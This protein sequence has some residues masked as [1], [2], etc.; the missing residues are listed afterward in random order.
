MT[1][2]ALTTLLV[3]AL[4]ATVVPIGGISQAAISLPHDVKSFV[5]HWGTPTAQQIED[6]KQFDMAVV[7]PYTFSDTQLKALHAADVMVIAY[8]PTTSIDQ[9]WTPFSG[10][11]ESDYL[12]LNG[13]KVTNTNDNPP[14]W[15]MDPRSTHYRQ[16]I[17]DYAKGIYTRGFD[18]VFLD[19]LAEATDY[20]NNREVLDAT[21]QLVREIRN[22]GPAKLICQNGGWWKDAPLNLIDYTAPLIDFMMW[23]HYPY[24]KGTGDSWTNT[25]R[26]HI[27]SLRN[28]YNFKV[29]TARFISWNDYTAVQRYYDDARAYGFAPYAPWTSGSPIYNTVNTYYLPPRSYTPAQPPTDPPAPPP[30]DPPAPPPTDPPA[31]PAP[32]PASNRFA[33]DVNS[34]VVHWG[35]PTAQQLQ[36]MKKFDLALTEPQSLSDAQLK[37]LQAAGVI[38]IGYVPTLSVNQ[39]WPPYTGLLNSDYIWV[40]GQ[41]VV[42]TSYP[43]WIMDPR[44]EHYRQIVSDYVRTVYARGFDGVFLAGISEPENLWKYVSLD[45]TILTNFIQE[46]LVATG[47]FV[48]GIRSINPTK[49]I[50]QD[51]G[52]LQLIDQT[53]PSI[54]GIVWPDYP[55]EKGASDSWLNAERNQLI[56][57]RNQYGFKVLATKFFPWN[58]YTG[59]QNFYDAS[60]AYGFVPYAPW[61]S[62][63]PIYNTVNTYNLPPRSYTPAPPPTEPPAPPPNE[64]PSP[65]VDPPAPPPDTQ[66]PTTP[67]ITRAVALSSTSVKITWTSSKDNVGVSRYDVYRSYYYYGT[68]NKV[69][70]VS[71]TSFTNT[72]LGKKTRYYYYIKAADAAGNVSSASNK[73]AV[74]TLWQ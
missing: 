62:G 67:T 43:D 52:W 66:A 64:P 24:D 12:W 14:D 5:I 18:G 40:N 56:S 71:G 22:A 49:L 63:T 41:K 15:I 57:S 38:V 44:S 23:E 74:R 11:M 34:F 32:P 7:E 28:Q 68:Y 2:K 9:K 10:I 50:I 31:P 21:V 17:T 60:R 37:E 42:N 19:T 26:D 54:D 20:S 69:A 25:K 55:Y 59:A 70:S 48:Q 35:A 36:D 46:L 73:M 58:D 30:T 6:M 33:H 13:Q 51:N 29:I 47:Q 3:I 61:T 45:S 27:I 4:M 8:I 39:Q 16:I 1:R 65:P 72:G 53:G